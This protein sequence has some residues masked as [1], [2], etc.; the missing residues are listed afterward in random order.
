MAMLATMMLQEPNAAE[1]RRNINM[2]KV[3]VS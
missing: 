3:G 1:R 2:A